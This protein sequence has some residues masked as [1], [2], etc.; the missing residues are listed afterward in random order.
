MKRD[1]VKVIGLTGG[2]GSGKTTVSHI[3]EALDVPVYYS[4]IRAKYLME[5]D[6]ELKNTLI[7]KF[8]EQ[9]YLKSGELNRKYISQVIFE[10]DTLLEWINSKVHPCVGRDFENWKSKQKHPFVIKETALLI[11]TLNHQKTDKII[12]VT[13]SK[14]IRLSRIKIRD[15]FSESEILARMNKQINDEERLKHADYVIH[16]DGTQ[17]ILSQTLAI[18]KELKMID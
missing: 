5:H 14:E 15:G 12:V 13:A 17:S 1:D 2:I 4:D 16:N 6:E 8:G 7:N 18:Y 3:F 9:A 10:N 11:E